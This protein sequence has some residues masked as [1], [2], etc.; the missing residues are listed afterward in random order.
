MPRGIEKKYL[1]SGTTRQEEG[2]KKGKKRI[3]LMRLTSRSSSMV[4]TNSFMICRMSVL[5]MMRVCV[6]NKRVVSLLLHRRTKAHKA[7]ASH[8]KKCISKTR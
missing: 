4:T 3:I 7:R 1:K 6:C 5:K 8:H 2:K